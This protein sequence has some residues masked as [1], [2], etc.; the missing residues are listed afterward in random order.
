MTDNPLANGQA[1]QVNDVLLWPDL[2]KECGEDAARL[3]CWRLREPLGPDTGLSD[4][5]L[6]EHL[7]ELVEAGLLSIWFLPG[8]DGETQVVYERLPELEARN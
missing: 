4:Q 2:V 7:K 6:L 5:K 1:I 8:P 3:L